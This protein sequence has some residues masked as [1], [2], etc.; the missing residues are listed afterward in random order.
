MPVHRD[1]GTVRQNE[2]GEVAEVLNEAENV[3]P[4]NKIQCL[5]SWDFFVRRVW[6]SPA[7]SRVNAG[8]RY[9][10]ITSLSVIS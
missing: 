3:I 1:F 6:Y 7:I 9:A 10:D 4:N 8:V 2:F 5:L